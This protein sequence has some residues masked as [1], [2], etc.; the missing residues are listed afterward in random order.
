LYD[1]GGRLVF[2]TRLQKEDADLPGQE[3]LKGALA[4]RETFSA[5][6]LSEDLT[7]VIWFLL[8]MKA[9]ERMSGVLAAQIDLMRMWEWVSSTKLGK[10]GYVS[11][12]DQNGIVVASGDPYY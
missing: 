5:S 12:V 3:L 7:P 1:Q 4:D 11:V 2:S 6:Y 10:S 8:P 9:N